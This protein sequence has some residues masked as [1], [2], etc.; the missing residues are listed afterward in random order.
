MPDRLVLHRDTHDVQLSFRCSADLADAL[1][2]AAVA[3]D[4]TISAEVRRIIRQYVQAEA[5]R[6][7]GDKREQ[8]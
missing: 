4:R 2:R 8:P 1:K 6:G 7:G 5:R 3:N